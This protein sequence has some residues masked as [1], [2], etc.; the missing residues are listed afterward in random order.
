MI[1]IISLGS[2]AIGSRSR[3]ADA[4]ALLRGRFDV[5]AVSD[6]YSTPALDGRSPKYFNAVAA[7]TTDAPI[8]QMVAEMKEIER[9]AGRRPQD[10]G[11][12]V[13]PLDLD[14][15]TCDGRVLRPADYTRSYFTIGYHQIMD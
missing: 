13:V 11:S 9:D 14:V 4:I 15:V 1:Y 12:R 3:V 5:R 7:V 10:H 2:N 8:E 6:I